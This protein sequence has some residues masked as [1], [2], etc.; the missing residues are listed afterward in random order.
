MT[1]LA[2]AATATLSV[3]TAS[4]NVDEA[5]SVVT[6]TISADTGSPAGYSV[7]T[8][9]SAMVTVEDN[10]TRDVSVSATALPVNEGTHGYL[11]GGA[12]QPAHGECDGD[13]VANG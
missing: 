5:N 13:A 9:A 2:N 11:H 6:A 4:D 12:E 8:P 1:F 10:D 7:G 3:T